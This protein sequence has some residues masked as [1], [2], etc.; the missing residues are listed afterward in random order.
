MEDKWLRI[1]KYRSKHNK[2]RVEV[3]TETT[4][5][6][7]VYGR[8]EYNWMQAISSSEELFDEDYQT[9]LS[10]IKNKTARRWLHRLYRRIKAVKYGNGRNNKTNFNRNGITCKC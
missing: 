6:I 2:I 8:R 4:N 9:A 3:H 1:Y 7:E 10:Y 5:L